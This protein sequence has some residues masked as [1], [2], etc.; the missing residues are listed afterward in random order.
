MWLSNV[1]PA[2]FPVRILAPPQQRNDP[3]PAGT[4]SGVALLV[5]RT[6]EVECILCSLL[7]HPN[8]PA[9]QRV[10][11]VCGKKRGLD[12]WVSGRES[13]GNLGVLG[14]VGVLDEPCVDVE[15]RRDAVAGALGGGLRAL[16]PAGSFSLLSSPGENVTDRIAA[17]PHRRVG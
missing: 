14:V 6:F 15:Q 4:Q 17:S 5:A 2:W 7:S 10:W 16:L 9:D 3:W 8:S 13:G 12:R 11:G 1:V